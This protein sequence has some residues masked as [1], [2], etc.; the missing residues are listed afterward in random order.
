[1]LVRSNDIKH[2]QLAIERLAP[3]E[4]DIL[5]FFVAE[6][7]D[8]DLNK[9]IQHL[10][11]QSITF[12]GG[13][14][15]GIVYQARHYSSGILVLKLPASHPP[16]LFPLSASNSRMEIWQPLLDK[17]NRTFRSCIVLVD[18]LS[19]HIREF[20][21]AV[22]HQ[23]GGYS[24]NY[25]GGGAG[26]IRLKQQPCVFTSA[27]I[28][29]DAAVMVFTPWESHIGVSH[30]WER[31]YGPIVATKTD[32]NT[33]KELNWQNAF[34]LYRSIVEGDCQ[35]PFRR[36]N[37]FAVAKQYP[38]GIYKEGEEDIVRDPIAVTEEGG[39]ICVGD[40][41]ENTAL[42][43]LR[44]DPEKLIAAARQAARRANDV[45][46][47]AF[48]EVLMADCISRVLF[49]EKAFQ[50]ELQAVASQ[51]H[52]EIPLPVKGILTLG[53]IASSGHLYLELFNKTIVIGQFYE[54]DRPGAVY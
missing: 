29:Q 51:V 7:T 25:F 48:R 36:E 9:L 54:T 43:I 23:L 21:T 52:P 17:I 31:L 2:I 26:S 18:G 44:G 49:L 50:Q 1:M 19:P 46:P 14:F 15:P 28:F 30:G 4:Q 35:T 53:E 8:L 5:L 24:F 34:D 10:N 42:Y 38:F 41:P 16:L 12:M 6:N 32:G 47:L 27:G 33:I 20:L 39:L 22:Y 13:V 40:V 37:F 3:T 45:A 11:H